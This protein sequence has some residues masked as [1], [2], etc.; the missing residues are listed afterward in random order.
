MGVYI[1]IKEKRRGNVD[2][3]IMEGMVGG[4]YDYVNIFE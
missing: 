3:V 2:A 4:E 1:G